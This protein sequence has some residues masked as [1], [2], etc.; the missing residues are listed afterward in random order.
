[1]Y[2]ERSPKK[3]H[4]SKRSSY[5]QTPRSVPTT[6]IPVQLQAVTRQML[7][8]DLTNPV[9]MPTS[10]L[11]L[12]HLQK[13]I[14]NQ[15]IAQMLSKSIPS[16]AA[17]LQFVPIQRKLII[18]DQTATTEHLLTIFE[19]LD[20]KKT[21]LHVCAQY[22]VDH[23]LFTA[24]LQ[25]EI[26]EHNLTVSFVKNKELA[27]Q[28]IG[29][30]VSNI[31]Q[32]LALNPVIDTEEEETTIFY[33]SVSEHV[34]KDDV[35]PRLAEFRNHLKFF[36]PSMK[37]KWVS[38]YQII[39]LAN[40]SQPIALER[41]A[42]DA[43][44]DEMENYL[45]DYIHQTKKQLDTVILRVE[46]DPMLAIV[47][48]QV[49]DYLNGFKYL[50]KKL[51]RQPQLLKEIND[52]LAFLTRRLDGLYADI[53]ETNPE[54]VVYLHATAGAIDDGYISMVHNNWNAGRTSPKATAAKHIHVNGHSENV[55]YT[56]QNSNKHLYI[57]GY[58]DW[59]LDSKMSGS[60][61]TQTSAIEAYDQ[62]LNLFSV[63]MKYEGAWIPQ[64]E[65]YEQA[66]AKFLATFP[67]ATE[68]R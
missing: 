46:S 35:M 5:L 28:Q 25:Q 42:V 60:E 62:N 56:M 29:H 53:R 47:A 1:M 48:P 8:Q 12:P 15:A 26:D 20:V 41:A 31:L 49:S 27:R 44:L 11:V 6:S 3:D 68:E 22:N 37:N 50:N 10:P 4:S 39:S 55:I 23:L 21:I 54:P 65:W 16:A 58:V 45:N 19:Q 13:Q 34:M 57:H 2:T 59:H 32:K 64:Q 14:G 30:I 52:N 36:P 51:L 67:L 24:I 43:T 61:Q 38:Y 40:P 63:Y 18:D 7:T 33:D 9:L 66:A 17:P